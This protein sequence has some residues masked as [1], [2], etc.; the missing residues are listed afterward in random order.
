MELTDF[1]VR[2]AGIVAGW[3][4]SA[5]EADHWCSMRM[6]PFDPTIVRLWASETDT[7]AYFG[8]EDGTPV[9]YGELWID[10]D[11]AEVELGRLIVDPQ[12]RGN[13]H[14]V[15]LVTGL[16]AAARHHHPTVT[17]RVRPDNKT[18]IGCYTSAGMQRADAADEAQWN[19][20]QPHEYHWFLAPQLPG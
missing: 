9:A 8:R 11:E 1:D 16:I 15:A 13:G 19:D 12:A 3:S 7:R 17:L 14:G 5:D 18:A 6:H 2:D 10:D 20:G 4:R